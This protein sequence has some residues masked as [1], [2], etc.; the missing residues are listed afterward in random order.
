MQSNLL[1]ALSKFPPPWGEGREGGGVRT[2]SSA[3]GS[4]YTRRVALRSLHVAVCAAVAA[5]LVNGCA[6]PWTSPFAAG[7]IHNAA[8]STATVRNDVPLQTDSAVPSASAVQANS[9]NDATSAQLA[10]VLDQLQQ[11]RAIDPTAES[12]LM[13]QLR[14]TPA[15]SWPL[16]AE[17]FRASLAY[18]EQLASTPARSVDSADHTEPSASAYSNARQRDASTS[19]QPMS[20]GVSDQA[21]AFSQFA[22]AESTQDAANSRFTP[23]VATTP[24][25]PETTQ[26]AHGMSGTTVSEVVQATLNATGP[27]T[28]RWPASTAN[29]SERWRPPPPRRHKTGSN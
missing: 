7:T 8:D 4:G 25:T 27:P 14:Q 9:P 2:A 28:V 20:D 23:I 24:A 1:T 17:Q 21:R 29:D 13:E 15:E 3:F 22:M 26:T 18:R 5:A 12:K 6:R 19:V 10:G 11:I 16:V